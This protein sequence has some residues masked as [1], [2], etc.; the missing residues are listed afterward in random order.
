MANRTDDVHHFLIPRKFKWVE[1]IKS[2]I[3][4]VQRKPGDGEDE[5]NCHQQPMPSVQALL[6]KQNAQPIILV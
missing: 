4:D 3:E 5:R 2:E 6:Q 1:E